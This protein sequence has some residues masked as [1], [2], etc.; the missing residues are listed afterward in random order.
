MKK[1]YLSLLLALML[2][3]MTLAASFDGKISPPSDIDPNFKIAIVLPNQDNSGFVALYTY[4]YYQVKLNTEKDCAGGVKAP[5]LD[6]NT[7]GAFFLYDI[8]ADGIM[9]YSMPHKIVESYHLSSAKTSDIQ[10]SVDLQ[11]ESGD[12]FKANAPKDLF[13]DN[14]PNAVDNKSFF[15][16]TSIKITLIILFGLALTGAGWFFWKKRNKKK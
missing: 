8:P 7:G 2:P 9:S 11:K 14:D 13:I 5:C 3:S 6:A 15:E 1:F 16:L 10:S 12:M 4:D